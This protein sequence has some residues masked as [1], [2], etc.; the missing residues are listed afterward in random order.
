M[1][2]SGPWPFPARHRPRRTVV[3]AAVVA[4]VGLHAP[5]TTTTVFLRNGEGVRATSITITTID[6]AVV[7][8]VSSNSNNGHPPVAV[9][10]L[11]A[12]VVV[13]VVQ[14]RMPVVPS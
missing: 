6:T 13:V 3:V 14:L 11:W 9:E 12:V 7:H 5:P 2:E 10:S 1:T 8:N 4:N